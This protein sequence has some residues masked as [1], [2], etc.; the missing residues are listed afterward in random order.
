MLPITARCRHSFRSEWA[1]FCCSKTD[2]RWVTQS[3][4]SGTK[5]AHYNLYLFK[6]PLHL[7]SFFLMFPVFWRRTRSSSVVS[8]AASTEE[9]AILSAGRK[10]HRRTCGLCFSQQ[11]GNCSRCCL[12]PFTSSDLCP[13]V[14]CCETCYLKKI[15]QDSDVTKASLSG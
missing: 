15:Q 13:L 1:F 10:Q 7:F 6:L 11:Q 8:V 9:A 2:Q 12:L 5:T 14:R 4:H 3:P